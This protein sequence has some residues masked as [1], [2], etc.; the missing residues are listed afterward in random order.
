MDEVKKKYWLFTPE[1]WPVQ[2]VMTRGWQTADI[3]A[4][5]EKPGDLEYSSGDYPEMEMWG[6]GANILND[7]DA[8]DWAEHHCRRVEVYDG[9]YASDFSS[10]SP[11]Q[12]EVEPPIEPWPDEIV[13][14]CREATGL[15]DTRTS[16]KEMLRW[17]PKRYQTDTFETVMQRFLIGPVEDELKRIE[18]TV[19]KF[20]AAQP[21]DLKLE[22]TEDIELVDEPCP[23]NR[24]PMSTCPEG[25]THGR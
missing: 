15:Y 12:V 16:Y 13:Q 14:L 19:S 6:D 11:G 9:F 23:V 7:E 2:R 3:D 17:L 22:E 4:V 24:R 25:C 8:N 5:G 21:K 20:I 1:G 18:D 10:Y